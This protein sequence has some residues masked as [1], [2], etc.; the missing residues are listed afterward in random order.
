MR[1]KLVRVLRLVSKPRADAGSVECADSDAH[2]RAEYDTVCRANSVADARTDCAAYLTAHGSA[3]H[4]FEHADAAAIAGTVRDAL[5]VGA[6]VRD[7]AML[8]LWRD[9]LLE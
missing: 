6:V 7:D 3:P 9:V 2:C 4:A 1:R 5:H 8:E